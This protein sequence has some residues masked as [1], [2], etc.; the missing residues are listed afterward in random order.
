MIVFPNAKINLGLQV[1]AKRSDGFHDIESFIYPVDLFDTLEIVPTYG[2]ETTLTVTGTPVQGDPTSNLCYKAYSLIAKMHP[3]PAVHIHLHKQ[4]PIGAGLGG[5]SSDAAFTLK[6]LNEL[7]TL[8]LTSEELCSYAAQLGSDCPFFIH[9]RSGI[10]TGRGEI[11]TPLPLD[12]SHY[13]IE[14]ISPEI[15][16]ST[17]EAY[18]L[19]DDYKIQ[20]PTTLPPASI[21]QSLL[22]PIETWKETIINDFESPLFAKYGALE[23]IKRDLYTKGAIYASMTGS[24]SSVYGIFKK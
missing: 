1:F 5:G 2:G 9:N 23:Q 3:I 24:G 21:Q 13:S 6:V 20:N 8:K 12:L 22:E 14:I 11:F 10:A 19:V 7:F 16:I 4:I 18:K 17:A 15:F